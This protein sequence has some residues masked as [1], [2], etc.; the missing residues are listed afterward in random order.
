[1][2]INMLP[3][4][5]AFSLSRKHAKTTVDTALVAPAPKPFRK[6]CRLIWNLLIRRK[7]PT[8]PSPRRL[9]P[10]VFMRTYSSK[11]GKP[12]KEISAIQSVGKLFG[13]SSVTGCR[14]TSFSASSSRPK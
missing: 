2:K 13:M 9:D 7:E 3:G 12:V 4:S 8:G 10:R 14:Y 5:S 6:G 1:M 11:V